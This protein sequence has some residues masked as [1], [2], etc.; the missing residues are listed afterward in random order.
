MLIVRNL[1]MCTTDLKSKIVSTVLAALSGLLCISV[2]KYSAGYRFQ[3]LFCLAA[4]A[5]E[6]E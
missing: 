4:E 6:A 5:I 1:K 2:Y 3:T